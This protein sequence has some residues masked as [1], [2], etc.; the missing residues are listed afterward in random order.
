M[1]EVDVIEEQRRNKFQNEKLQEK[2]KRI[3]LWGA[4]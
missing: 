1:N 3:N 4:K 2:A